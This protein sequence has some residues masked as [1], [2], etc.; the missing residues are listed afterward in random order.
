MFAL[1]LYLF[2]KRE[3]TTLF[4]QR[5][6]DKIKQLLWRKKNNNL[7]WDIL[8]YFFMC[9]LLSTVYIQHCEHDRKKG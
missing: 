5:K 9:V 7:Q 8:T 6:N 4:L 2:C 3:E 1:K